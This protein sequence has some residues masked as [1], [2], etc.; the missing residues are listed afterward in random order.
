MQ[1]FPNANLRL[2]LLEINDVEFEMIPERKPGQYR[3]RLVLQ[4]P[5]E[6]LQVRVDSDRM[7]Q[8][9]TKL[10]S[11]AVKFSPPERAVEGNVF[12]IAKGVPLEVV[13]HGPAIPEEFRGRIFQK[14]SQADSSDTRQK[15]GSGL[16]LNISR[17]LIEKMGGQIGFSS[18]ADEGTSFFLEL[19]EWQKPAPL[20]QPVRTQATS[21]RPRILVCDADFARH[22]SMM[23]GKAGFDADIAHHATQA[24]AC[25][26]RNSYDAVTVDLKLPGQSGAA[27]ISELRGN[28]RTRNLTV[29][30]ISAMDEEGLLQF[31]RKPLTVS[32]W[33]EKPVDENL[34]ILSMR[35][36]V[37]GLES[38]KPRILHVEDDPDIQSIVAAI[39]E[40]F[41]D[42]E[43][44]A[45]LSEARAQL[46]EHRFDLVLLD[47]AL[48]ND[49]GWDL[50]EDIDALDPPPPVIV[51][52]A[53][54]VDRP[55]A[56]RPR[57]SWSKPEH[58]TP[59]C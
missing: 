20:L 16:G 13:N 59:S 37:A 26:E 17:A 43:F 14:F 25:L 19:P 8:A 50:F 35:R 49:S 2:P 21:S 18:E 15:G 56:N 53:S 30:V 1:S 51:F 36:V 27:F 6:L 22:I 28:E 58:P 52:S 32:G 47:L 57:R 41:A 5:E 11:N 33:L 4:A 40:D 54:D 55:K 3:V 9:L 44:A 12:R 46:R 38:G 7:I 29:V 39:A 48:D 24:R 42:F 34:L 10:L 31:N 23:L 45:T